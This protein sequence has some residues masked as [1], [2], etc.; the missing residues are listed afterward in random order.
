M[1]LNGLSPLLQNNL[2]VN[3]LTHYA[4]GFS[5]DI[6]IGWPKYAIVKVIGVSFFKGDLNIFITTR[7][8]YLLILREGRISLSYVMGDIERRQN[9]IILCHGRY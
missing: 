3:E 5:Q 4:Q 1:K 8:M 6:E 7:N 9:I 2:I